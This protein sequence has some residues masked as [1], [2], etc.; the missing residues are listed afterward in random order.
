MLKRGVARRGRNIIPNKAR[1]RCLY[2]CDETDGENSELIGSPMFAD[3]PKFMQ[4]PDYRTWYHPSGAAGSNSR[5][6][7]DKCRDEDPRGAG[8]DAFVQSTRRR[9]GWS[10]SM[11]EAK[12]LEAR[13][14]GEGD[15]LRRPP[16]WGECVKNRK[17]RSSMATGGQA[18]RGREPDGGRPQ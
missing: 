9:V 16:R 18:R 15:S 7:V 12:V 11:L 3:F 8:E 14:W 6:V 5:E 17:A 2:G 4:P 1:N 10:S 13:T